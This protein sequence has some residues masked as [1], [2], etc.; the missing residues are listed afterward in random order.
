MSP[1]RHLYLIPVAWAALRGGARA[2]GL[3]GLMAGFFQVPLVLPAIERAGLT[4]AAVE[5][6]VSLAL[7][8]AVGVIAGMLRDESRARARRLAALLE[9]EQ[10]LAREA[11]L[12]V[13]LDGVAAVV[14]RGLKAARVGVLVGTTGDAPALGSAPPGARLAPGSAA[15]WSL[16]TARPVRSADLA[17]DARFTLAGPAAPSPRRGLIL[18]MDA[19]AGTVGVLALEWQGEVAAGT[20]AA[21]AEIA[22]HLALGV[23]NARLTMRQRRFAGELE[24]KVAAATRRLRE[25]DQAKSE[26]LSVV[27]HELRTPLTALEG[28]AELLLTR[29]VPP[30]RAARFLRHIHAE[31]RRLGRIVAELLDLSRLEVGV[32]PDL[33]REPIDLAAHVERQLELFAGVHPG[34]R[35]SWKVEGPLPAIRA[36]R[37]ALDRVLQNLLSNAVKYSPRGGEVRVAARAAADGLVELR[38][39]DEGVGI[40]ARDIPRIFDKY[41]RIANQETASVRGLGLGLSLVRALVEAHGGR[42]E[43][44]SEAG[45]GSI[46][47]VILP[48]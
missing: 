6:L 33:K 14:R 11:P 20:D 25:I 43:V 4:G 9:I 2:G 1:L 19:G 44:E 10:C 13:R 24:D 38:V 5:G 22:L 23:E 16:T 37:D 30:E 39:E 21:A 7:P 31:A 42:I 36:D 45:K 28:F 12:P 40:P 47:R 8:P 15:D 17:S 41:V 46:F 18:P 3:L 48:V 35:F 34:H 26:F 32:S 29:A 27:S